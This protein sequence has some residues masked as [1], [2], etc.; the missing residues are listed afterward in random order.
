MNTT[1]IRRWIK[2]PGLRVDELVIGTRTQT[3]VRI[4][5]LDEVANPALVKEVKRRLIG[6]FSRRKPK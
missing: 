5:Y 1:M 2:D 6:D 4:L 3:L